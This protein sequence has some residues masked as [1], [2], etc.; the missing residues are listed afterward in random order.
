MSEK[1]RFG[2][3]NASSLYVPMSDVEQEALMRLVESQT[4]RIRVLGWNM[5]DIIPQRV[6]Y[7]DKRVQITFQV[8]F[9]ALAVPTPLPQLAVELRTESGIVLFR[10]VYP[11][12]GNDGRPIEIVGGVAFDL[13]WDIAI[14]HW[15]P[16]LVKMLKPGALGLTSRR[17]DKDTGHRTLLGNMKVGLDD[18][19][20][21]LELERAE[22]QAR[23]LDP[24][25]GKKKQ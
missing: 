17:I 13:Q 2:G 8:V 20:A 21:L 10:K 9:P 14:D 5:P 6:V 16:A 4:L 25:E 11:T 23:A 12:V 3:G 7:G 22:A 19:Q 1:N 18:R 15:D 24:R